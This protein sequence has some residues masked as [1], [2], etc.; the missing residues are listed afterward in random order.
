MLQ[1]QCTISIK[2]APDVSE[3]P[4]AVCFKPRWAELGYLVPGDMQPPED[5]PLADNAPHFL[6]L[7]D[8]HVAA[9]S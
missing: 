1:L 9:G 7:A 5:W 4:W 8:C 6:A 2:Y 3:T